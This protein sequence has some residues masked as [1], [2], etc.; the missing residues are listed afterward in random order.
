MKRNLVLWA[1]QVLLAALFVFAGGM[2]LVLPIE[3]MTG[4]IALPGALLRFVGLAELAGGLGLL[5]PGMTGIRRELTPLAAVGLVIIMTG[6]TVIT[7]LSGSIPGALF[8]LVVGVLCGSIAHG[9]ASWTRRSGA[10][11][12]QDQ[13]AAA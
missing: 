2:K 11:S 1:V 9:R 5:L 6:A 8:P 10:V 3:A 7:V 13:V 4:A 12:V